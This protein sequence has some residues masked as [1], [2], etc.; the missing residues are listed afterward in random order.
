ML[1]VLCLPLSSPL[2]LQ[3]PTMIA[4]P[5]VL[6]WYCKQI[7]Q[8]PQLFAECCTNFRRRSGMC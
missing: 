8:C 7:V 6:V 1:S 4:M 5:R 2:T 3:P